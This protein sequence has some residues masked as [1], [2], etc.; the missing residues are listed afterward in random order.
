[1][2]RLQLAT[3][4][5]EEYKSE[6]KGQFK[7]E[8]IAYLL[9]E[10]EMKVVGSKT[11]GKFMPRR[12]KLSNPLANLASVA[13][14]TAAFRTRHLAEGSEFPVLSMDTPILQLLDLGGV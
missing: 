8:Q 12:L 2:E 13:G 3:E 4:T 1:M 10:A 11:T 7:P 5:S 6:K 14:F 9:R